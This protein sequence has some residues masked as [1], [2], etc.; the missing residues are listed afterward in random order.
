MSELL[1]AVKDSFPANNDV[2]VPLRSDITLTLS[3]LDYDEDSLTEGFFVEGPDTDQ[4]IGPGLEILT[5]PDN[6]SQGSL[7]DFLKS[8]GYSGLVQGT[9]TVSGI[10]GDTV[11]TFDPTQPL[12]ASVDYTVNLG[13]VLRSDG[14]TEVDGFVTLSFQTGSGSIQEIP[15]TVSTS[16][17]RPATPTAITDTTGTPLSVVKI[18]PADHSVENSI[19]TREVV[20]EFNKNIDPDTVNN[21][22]VSLVATAV[23]DH[24][25]LSIDAQ[26]ELV[27]VLEVSG[28][29]LRITI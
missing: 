1:D 5:H 14:T 27:K 19:D 13:A 6:I 25:N 24:P 17:L 12:A 7:D 18:T 23:T 10:S 26:G 3:G 8:P 28:K 22:S 20:I 16:V 2:G 4:F 29:I 15:S 21:D 9:T 11:I